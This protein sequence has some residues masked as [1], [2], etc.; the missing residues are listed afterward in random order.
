MSGAPDGAIVYEV[1]LDLEAAVAA[2]YR[3]WLD[4]HV[5][6]LLAL[7][8]FVSAEVFEVLEP[9]AAGRAGLCVQYRLRDAVA[10]ETYL[11]E[12]APRMRAEGLARFGERVRASRR[13][14]RAVGSTGTRD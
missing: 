12:H 10:L 8:G 6:R 3:A 9:V 14:L 4:A 7:P 1:D 2:E 13:V 5:P 11:R